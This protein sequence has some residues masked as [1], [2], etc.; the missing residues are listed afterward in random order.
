MAPVPKPI[1]WKRVEFAMMCSCNQEEIAASQGVHI[2]TLRDRFREH[3]GVEYSAFSA[4][5]YQQG[6]LLLR[7]AQM[8]NALKGNS[9]MQMFLGKVRLGQ[10]EPD[11]TRTDAPNEKNLGVEHELLSMQAEKAAK[12]AEIAELKEKLRANGIQ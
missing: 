6:D 3:Y 1:D 11:G 7:E 2:D 12:E 4:M 9:N 10:K 5:L 8:K